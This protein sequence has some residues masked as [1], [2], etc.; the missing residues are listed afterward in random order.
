ML[1]TI[2]NN[3][4]QSSWQLAQASVNS[5]A[6]A[7]QSGRSEALFTYLKTMAK[8]PTYSARNVLLIAAQHPTATHLEGMR[9]WNDLDRKSTRL[10]SSHSQI[11][12]AVFCLKKKTI[13]SGQGMG[14]G[15]AVFRVRLL[16]ASPNGPLLVLVWSAPRAARRRGGWRT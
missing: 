6:D 5:L 11:S 2:Q 15:A 10:N 9:S 4:V 3:Q 14:G 12:Y 16:V 8:F 1:N 13:P 7:I